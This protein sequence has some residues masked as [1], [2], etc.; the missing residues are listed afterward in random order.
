MLTIVNSK[1]PL[2][3][4]VV[5]AITSTKCVKGFCTIGKFLV[6]KCTTLFRFDYNGVIPSFLIRNVFVAIEKV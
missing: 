1:S 2:E 6:G 3:F 5:F 4:I